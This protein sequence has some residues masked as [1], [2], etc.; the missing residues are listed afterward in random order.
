MG[1]TRRQ[2]LK[3]GA[4]AGGGLLVPWGA[5]ASMASAFAKP[6]PV[7]TISLTSAQKFITTWPTER[8]TPISATTA[9]NYELRIRQFT[10]QILPPPYHKTQVACYGSLADGATAF[11]TPARPIVTTANNTVTVKWINDQVDA[12]GNFLPHVLADE[13][14]PSA[15]WANPPGPRPDTIGDLKGTYR[16]PVPIVPHLHGGEGS[17]VPNDY[18]T[19]DGHP[20]AWFLPD[21]VNIPAGYLKFGSYYSNFRTEFLNKHGALWAPGTATFIYP[22]ATAGKKTGNRVATL[23]WAHDHTLGITEHNVYAGFAGGY[24]VTGGAYDLPPGVLPDVVGFNEFPLVIQD[25]SFKLDGSLYFGNGDGNIKIVNG[26]SYPYLNVEPRRYRF[27]ILN[28]QN[29]HTLDLNLN[30]SYTPAY[31]IGSDIGFC[32]NPTPLGQ[33]LHMDCAERADVIVDFT[34]LAGTMVYL[35]DGDSGPFLQFRVGSSLSTPD[36]TTPVTALGAL[37]VDRELQTPGP[38]RQVAAL[39]SMIGVFVGGTPVAVT[40][41][42]PATETPNAG[43]DEIWEVY[44]Y[45]DHPMHA[46][47]GHVEILNRQKFTSTVAKPPAAWETGVKDTFQVRPGEITRVRMRFRTGAGQYVWHCHTLSHEDEGMMRQLVVR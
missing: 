36:T 26:V 7:P 4:V 39:D 19:S 5:K 29:N 21:A 11:H 13:L 42:D 28:G 33:N 27:R 44:G 30:P 45:N 46:H 37:P 12:S 10:Q 40:M 3:L 22:G 2:F 24:L 41:D 1:T 38:K 20:F 43:T 23:L 18:E 8:L 17:D 47:V 25:R 6:A 16:G 9:N 34:G 32:A 31:V 14:K 35:Q 15:E